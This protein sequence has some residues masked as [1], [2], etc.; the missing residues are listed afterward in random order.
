VRGGISLKTLKIYDQERFEK[1]DK[2]F[3]KKLLKKGFDLTKP[4]KRER[5]SIADLSIYTQED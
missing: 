4:Y 1:G 3:K 2:W 5:E